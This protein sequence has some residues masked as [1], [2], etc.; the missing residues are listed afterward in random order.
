MSS[1][2][3]C[4]TDEEGG[5]EKGGNKVLERPDEDEEVR[6]YAQNGA[7][8][9]EEDECDSELEVEEEVLYDT[10]SH[11]TLESSS[12]SGESGMT[13]EERCDR[14][15]HAAHCYTDYCSVLEC[16]MYDSRTLCLAGTSMWW[17]S[18]SRQRQREM[19]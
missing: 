11:E 16:E 5:G 13:W 2:V 18:G 7:I 12:G 17:S 19:Y 9:V 8:S 10:T 15:S 4:V 6:E 1:G 3:L 14:T